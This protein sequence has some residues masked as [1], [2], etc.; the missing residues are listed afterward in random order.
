MC[1]WLRQVSPDFRHIAAVATVLGDQQM[2]AL[3]I[4]NWM[5]SAVSFLHTKAGEKRLHVDENTTLYRKKSYE[6]LL[7]INQNLSV[8]GN[9][10]WTDFLA[11]KEPKY[12]FTI[13]Y[14]RPYLP[15]ESCRVRHPFRKC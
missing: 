2:G 10:S 5:K 4:D 9:L 13:I 14:A 1:C 3:A 6:W 7:A 11:P 8:L 12:M 15:T